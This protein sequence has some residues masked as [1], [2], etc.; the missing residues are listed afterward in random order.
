MHIAA[1]FL[2]SHMVNISISAIGAMDSQKLFVDAIFIRPHIKG[3]GMCWNRGFQGG[4][5]VLR[6]RFLP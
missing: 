5:L 6:F 3:G 2:Y 1:I 4:G